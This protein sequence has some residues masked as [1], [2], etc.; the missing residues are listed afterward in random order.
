MKIYFSH[1]KEINFQ[2]I[3]HALRNSDLNKVHEIILPHEK[4]MEATDF[5][6][7]DIINECDLVVAETTYP[8]TGMG[9][10]L[11][12]A[13]VFGKRIVCF[14]KEGAKLSSSLKV[15]SKDFVQYDD[16]DDFIKKL[17]IEINKKN[18]NQ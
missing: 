13:D 6:T 17:K 12:R 3:Y 8:A 5:V 1:S 2:E 4:S 16:V 7:R 9:I 18:T 11:G 15:V 14:Y 10:E